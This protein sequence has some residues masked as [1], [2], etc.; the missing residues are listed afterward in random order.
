MSTRSITSRKSP[1]PCWGWSGPSK[2]PQPDQTFDDVVLLL[3]SMKSRAEEIVARL[4]G[5]RA[6]FHGWLHQDEFGP[7]RGA[8]SAALRTHISSVKT[9][10]R[11]LQKTPSCFRCRLD[12]A[13][14]NRDDGVHSCLEALEGAAAD[15]GFDAQDHWV[16][17]DDL[18]WFLRIKNCVAAAVLQ[19]KTLDDSTHG[20]IVL[21]AE[22]HGFEAESS[23]QLDFAQMEQWLNGYWKILIETLNSLCDRRGRPESVSLHLIGLPIN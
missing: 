19:F 17:R 2:L 14:R 5:L 21:T 16:N 22:A 7:S 4:N 13:I 9:L 3:P 12:L 10:C 20:E 23:G 18:A 1:R 6:L 8:Q 15:V 11:L